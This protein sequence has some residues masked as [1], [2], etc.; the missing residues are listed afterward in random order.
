MILFHTLV[1]SLG[2][3]VLAASELAAYRVVTRAVN[4]NLMLIFMFSLLPWAKDTCFWSRQASVSIEAVG[5]HCVLITSLAWV[6]L[7]VPPP[8]RP[9]WR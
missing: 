9:G 4:V 1:S 2:W 8:A 5:I 7:A 6:R 3:Q